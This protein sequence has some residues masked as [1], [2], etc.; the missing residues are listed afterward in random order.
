MGTTP[1]PIIT[2]SHAF[3]GPRYGSVTAFVLAA[4]LL[5]VA[6]G[7]FLIAPAIFA[8]KR[9]GGRSASDVNVPLA[10]RPETA[11]AA[12]G[13]TLVDISLARPREMRGRVAK[14]SER[15]S[16]TRPSARAR[17]PKPATPEK[18]TVILA[19]RDVPSFGDPEPD[20][21]DRD[22]TDDQVEEPKP[23]E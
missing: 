1:R 3:R 5:A 17:R 11:I 22:D 23:V 20:S 21:R 18:D 12:P 6:M 14:R 16:R 19:P 4:I 10:S 8:D 2:A 15:S 9:P 13:E 7:R